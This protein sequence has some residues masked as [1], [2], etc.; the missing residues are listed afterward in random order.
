M[1]L[2]LVVS[3]VLLASTAARADAPAPATYWIQTHDD[4][5]A[6]IF[7]SG[8]RRCAD[9]PLLRKDVDTGEIVAL[10]S[11]LDEQRFVDQCVPAGHYQYGLATPYACFVS[12]S[13]YFGEATVPAPPEG[14]TRTVEA[15]AAATAVPWGDDPVICKSSYTG[16]GQ[17]CS[18][19]GAVMGLNLAVLA[20][21]L[22]LWRRRAGRRA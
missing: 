19:G 2:E 16:P 9:G 4:G 10:T 1:R 22:A 3:A 18:T 17:G 11:C 14:C 6:T 13:A 8:D 5:S 12:G 7:L 15:P 21:G 20:A